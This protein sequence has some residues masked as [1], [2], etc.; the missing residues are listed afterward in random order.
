MPPFE[1]IQLGFINQLGML[2]NL[3]FGEVV[4]FSLDDHRELAL[5]DSKDEMLALQ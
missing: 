2:D 4:E 3:F 1:L 5:V